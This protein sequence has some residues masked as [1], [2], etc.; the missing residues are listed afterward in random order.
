MCAHDWPACRIECYTDSRAGFWPV[1]DSLRGS[2]CELTGGD[3]RDVACTLSLYA[4]TDLVAMYSGSD[5]VSGDYQY[6]K[7]PGGE[8]RQRAAASSAW[9]A[10]CQ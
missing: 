2:G 3:G 7:C 4:D 5:S 8:A 10:R 6:P 1:F 9:V